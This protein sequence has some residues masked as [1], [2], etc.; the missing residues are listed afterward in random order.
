[1]PRQELISNIVARYKFAKWPS[2]EEIIAGEFVFKQGNFHGTAIDELG[3]YSDGVVVN[4]QA[5]VEFANT[6]IEDG[7]QWLGDEY[8]YEATEYPPVRKIYQSE[9]VVQMD[10]DL[11]ALLNPF[12][13]ICDRLN[14]LVA[15]HYEDF[16]P[17]ELSGI[18]LGFDPSSLGRS[19]PGGFRLERRINEPYANK[20]YY[21]TSPLPTHEHL[22]L[23]KAFESLHTE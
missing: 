20:V 5:T 7:L 11:P 16:T 19:V 13:R 4:T 9:L 23:L 21:S 6:F 17:Y 8:G 10:V 22:A 3:V 14:E 12:R 15:N 2:V 1:M 18:Y